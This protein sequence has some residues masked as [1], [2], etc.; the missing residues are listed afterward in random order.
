[1]S[2]WKDQA[3]SE[4]IALQRRKKTIE[5]ERGEDEDILN[6]AL[7]MKKAVEKITELELPYNN[8]LLE[9]DTLIE[10]LEERFTEGWDVP[11]KTYKCDTGEATLRTTKALKINNKESLITLLSDIG[12]LS[13]CIRS[14]N[15]SY[16]RKLKDVDLIDD[17]I[18]HYDENQNVIVK[19]VPSE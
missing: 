7:L 14:W 3:I 6:A 12:K 19:G 2:N 5:R 11:E 9:I 16:L 13:E 17:T 8:T 4:H 18:A 1:V 15:L 10:K